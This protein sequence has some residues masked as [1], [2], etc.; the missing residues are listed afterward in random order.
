MA[1][2]GPTAGVIG[3][4]MVLSRAGIGGCDIKDKGGIDRLKRGVRYE[5]MRAWKPP[6]GLRTYSIV[7]VSTLRQTSE[8]LQVMWRTN[9]FF[10]IDQ[11]K[12]NIEVSEP[13]VQHSFIY[14][15]WLNG[16]ATSPAGMAKKKE[17]KEMLAS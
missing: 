9:Q 7:A 1:D 8:P 5:A 17:R 3:F 12:P 10:S 16:G 14:G 15:A 2:L 6:A 11:T 13:P 4:S